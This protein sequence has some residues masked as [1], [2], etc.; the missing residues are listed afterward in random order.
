MEA[1]KLDDI[2]MRSLRE[3]QFAIFLFEKHISKE[4]S[5]S[6]QLFSMDPAGRIN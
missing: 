1:D 6:V 5:P 3:S 4:V 2:R